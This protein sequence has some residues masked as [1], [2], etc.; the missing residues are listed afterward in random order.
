MHGIGCKNVNTQDPSNRS[1]SNTVTVNVHKFCHLIG[2]VLIPI[3]G[4][5]KTTL[6]LAYKDCIS[7]ISSF[8]FSQ[9]IKYY[10]MIEL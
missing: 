4:K 5:N 9:Y 8:S 10:K 3:T 2:Q 1:T 6:S 7:H